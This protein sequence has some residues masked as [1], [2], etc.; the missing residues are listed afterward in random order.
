MEG[1]SINYLSQTIDT[2]VK[3]IIPGIIGTS[4]TLAI[5][6]KK[7]KITLFRVIL[8]FIIGVGFVFLLKDIVLEY[9]NETFQPAMFGIIG[10]SGE[11]IGRFLISIFSLD[12]RIKVIIDYIVEAMAKILGMGKLFSNILSVII[13][14][15]LI[16]FGVIL[17]FSEWMR[18]FLIIT[19]ISMVFSRDTLISRIDKIID[20]AIGFFSKKQ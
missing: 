9:V 11:Y 10:M 3:F 1:K 5:A 14:I 17:E 15:G 20:G 12:I 6:M 2:I 19:G 4:I 13:G 8:S 7:E 16:Y 18:I